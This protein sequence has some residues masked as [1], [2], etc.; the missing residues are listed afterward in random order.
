MKN[1]IA[2]FQ[3]LFVFCL[4][5]AARP[6][7][8]RPGDLDSH[9]HGD[10]KLRVTYEVL[11]ALESASKVLVQ[12][13]GKILMVGTEGTCFSVTRFT[14]EG[15]LDESFNPDAYPG[16]LVTCIG[17]DR[18]Y[19]AALQQDGK[20]LITGSVDNKISVLRYTAEGHLDS[21]FNSKGA[22]PGLQKLEEGTGAGRDL[23][24]QDD[25]TIL[26]AAEY[27]DPNHALARNG[28]LLRLLP[29]G[30]IDQD[31]FQGGLFLDNPDGLIKNINVFEA[32]A[33]GPNHHFFV[34]NLL[35]SSADGTKGIIYS[36]LE[37]GAPDLNFMDEGVATPGLGKNFTLQ[38]IALQSDGKI[39]FAGNL[40]DEVLQ[41]GFVFVSRLNSDGSLDPSYGDSGLSS[42]PYVENYD[43][44]FALVV[45]DNDQALIAGS[46]GG[47]R[48]SVSR[49]NAD[50]SLD[51]D[52]G[53][54]GVKT[55]DFGGASQL[56]YSVAVQADGKILLAGSVDQ[57]FAMA[58]LQGDS[59]DLGMTGISDWSDSGPIAFRFDLVNRGPNPASSVDFKVK[60]PA[61]LNLLSIEHDGH[62][63]QDQADLRCHVG[64][65]DSGGIASITVLAEPVSPTSD[66]LDLELTAEVSPGQVQDPDLTNNAITL[67]HHWENTTVA[68]GNNGG[69]AGGCTLWG[70]S[71][72]L[73]LSIEGFFFFAVMSLPLIFRPRS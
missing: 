65:L 6:L 70:V 31:F 40:W 8:A 20:I 44:L 2:K 36:F 66:G 63:C 54:G 22:H 23:L 46:Q 7:W 69:S 45:Q 16:H 73:D 24:V 68:N 64:N 17:S 38:D 58:R 33:E 21:N 71:S 35:S 61:E 25:G 34:G 56:A 9:F 49:L 26:V 32:I 12:E 11:P 59:A 57:D 53:L 10:G 18:A 47:K 5:L 13:D 1:K 55:V 60:L 27:R 51:E 14:P 48:M 50:G 42:F 72:S 62:G 41:Q 15:L 39:L 29:N 30:S 3:I 52:F 43:D 4:S 19:G 67:S 37:N 28:A